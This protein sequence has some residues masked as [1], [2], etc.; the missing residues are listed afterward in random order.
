MSDEVENIKAKVLQDVEAEIAHLEKS[1]DDKTQIQM[2]KA[3]AEVVEEI[4]NELLKDENLE[5]S[6]TKLADIVMKKVA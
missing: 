3:K 5:L 1:F 4:L 2:K 6:Q